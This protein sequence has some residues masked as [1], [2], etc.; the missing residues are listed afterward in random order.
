MASAGNRHTTSATT[1][2][3]CGVGCVGDVERPSP[4]SLVGPR[5]TVITALDAANKTG[6][7]DVTAGAAGNNPFRTR[8]IPLDCQIR[9]R[10]DGGP[11]GECS[12]YAVL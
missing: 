1:G 5:R 2:S 8:K 12:A 6:K 3:G 10:Y 9:P 7:R 11:L 4:S